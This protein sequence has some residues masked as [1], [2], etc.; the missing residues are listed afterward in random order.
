MNH[1]PP[2]GWSRQHNYNNTNACSNQWVAGLIFKN[3]Y[4]IIN[5][6]RKVS[7][8]SY[9]SGKVRSASSESFLLYIKMKVIE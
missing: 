1:L 7:K 5:S 9:E 3:N 4:C 8:Y 6:A 2:A